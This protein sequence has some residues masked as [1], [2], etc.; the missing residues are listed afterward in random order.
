MSQHQLCPQCQQPAPAPG[1]PIWT[2]TRVCFNCASVSKVTIPPQPERRLPAPAAILNGPAWPAAH[3][4]STDGTLWRHQSIA[5]ELFINGHNIVPSTPTASGKSLIFQLATF[6][7]LLTDPTATAIISYPMKALGNDQLRRWH[8][9]AQHLGFDTDQI[10]KIDGDVPYNTREAILNRSRIVI[11]T[12]DVC[13]SWLAFRCASHAVTN[14]L[15]NL[16]V[17]IIDESHTYE[18]VF[19]TNAAYLFR[20]LNALTIAAGN[21]RTPQY[22]G[23][24]ATIQEPAAHLERLT[25]LPF[26]AITEA[27]NGAPRHPRQL[28]HLPTHPARSEQDLAGL[29]STIIDQ[30][31][32]GQIIAFMDSRQGTE[33]VA[34]LVNR[35]NQVVAYRSGYL[36]TDRRRIEDALRA[37]RLKAVIATS[38][39]EIGIDMPDLNYGINHDLPQT[40]KQFHQRLGR[41]GRSQPGTF[42]VLAPQDRLSMFG[43]DLNSYYTDHIEH[44]QLYLENRSIM[45]KHALCIA[46]EAQSMSSTPDRMLETGSWPETFRSTIPQALAQAPAN[47]RPPHFSHSLRSSGEESLDILAYPHDNA[48]TSQQPERLGQMTLNLA[49]REAYPGAIYRHRGE[50]YQVHDWRRKRGD[51]QPFLKIS[52]IT[53]GPADRTYPITRRVVTVSL[54]PEH[55]IDNNIIATDRGVIAEVHATLTESV[56][57][58]TSPERQDHL[59]HDLTRNQNLSRKQR[60]YSTTALFISIPAPWFSG[61]PAAREQI[62]NMLRRHLAHH[63]SIPLPNIGCAHDNVAVA[64]PAGAYFATDAIVIFDTIQGGL[65][66]CHDLFANLDRYTATIARASAT[67]LTRRATVSPADANRFRAWHQRLA[68][69]PAASPPVPGPD[70]WWRILRPGSRVTLVSAKKQR[71]LPEFQLDQ[72][73]W[74]DGIAYRMAFSANPK[75][76]PESQ[77]N[78]NGAATD[79][80]AWH[81]KSGQI[82]DLTLNSMTDSVM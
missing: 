44:S 30:D 36:D 19:G 41:I 16:R 15:A 27:D 59:Y 28:L 43:D 13:H 10:T 49:L 45:E 55:V 71:N 4:D 8:A 2:G 67:E 25:G 72:P 5:L 56:E 14:F 63:R 51:S 68:S 42:I 60:E 76:T 29:I 58:F 32:T 38:A 11:M 20:R 22:I 79:W 47:G 31:P 3:A 48:P 24:T 57:G 7:T 81:P 40:R 52:P 62:A 21:R 70:T 18:S 66:L 35:P 37:G 39:L 50:T 23:A 82:Q 54:S 69:R 1:N 9:M 53:A 61:N 73:A 77:I 12:P 33:R 78:P 75:P 26:T 65:R 6:H 46:I 64:T 34:A 80:Q 17:Y 74:A